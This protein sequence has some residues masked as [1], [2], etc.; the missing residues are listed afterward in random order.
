MT[1]P[2]DITKINYQLAKALQFINTYTRDTFPLF[3]STK[4]LA[5]N[6]FHDVQG[7]QNYFP[8]TCGTSEALTILGVAFFKA[9]EATNDIQWKNLGINCAE[10]YRNYFHLDDLFTTIPNGLDTPLVR[11]HWL[12]VVRL[13]K[14]GNNQKTE[15]LSN[16]SLVN[17][18][19]NFGYF[20]D[21]TFINGVAQLNTDLSRVFK[22][23]SGELEYKNVYAPLKNGMNYPIEYWVSEGQKAYPNGD[24]INTTEPNGRVKLTQNFNGTLNII[25]A[26]FDGATINPPSSTPLLGEHFLEPYPI[27]YKCKQ[28]GL[29]YTGAA[30]DA[31]WWS[32]EMY[33]IA[34]KHTNLAKYNNAKEIIK[35]NTLKYAGLESQSYFYQKSKS[36]EPLSYPGSYLLQYAVDANGV[37]QTKPGFL[38]SRETTI[39]NKLE[40]LK[41][42][43]NAN[44]NANIFSGVELQNY[45][46]QVFF[47]PLVKINLETASSIEN[48]L[49]IKI[50]LATNSNDFSQDY[51]AYKIVLG[52]SQ[53]RGYSFG[54]EQF[55]KFEN[56]NSWHPRI[57]E[58]P[59]FVFNSSSWLW[60][61]E[62][63][64]GVLRLF[65]ETNNPDS[66]AGFGLIN[67]KFSNKLP[68]IK[69]KLIG[70]GRF[71]FRDS[72][73][74]F[75]YINIAD[76]GGSW[77]TFN[78]SWQES[79]GVGD[80]Q[81]LELVFENTQNSPSILSLLYVGE[82]GKTIPVPVK[83]YKASIVDKNRLAHTWWVGDFQPLNNSLDKLP[84]TPGS[85]PFTINTLN[86]ELQGFRG[87]QFYMAYQSPYNLSKWGYLQYGKNVVQML[88][89]SQDSY[90]KQSIDKISGLL[91]Q[92]FLP[93]DNENIAYLDKAKT[94]ESVLS[95]PIPFLFDD[96]IE[97]PTDIY[98]FN[99]FSWKGLDPN[100]EWAP[101]CF[102]A[103]ED[104]SRYYLDN[105]GDRVARKV[106]ENYI[107]FA[108]AWCITNP[109]S[110]IT[111]IVPE[112]PP[113]AN[114]FEPHAAAIEGIT[115]L[116]CNL[117]GIQQTLSWELIQFKFNYID[118]QF[119]DLGNMQGSWCKNQPSFSWNNQSY[120][121]DFTFWKGKIIEFYSLCTLSK[122]YI[123]KG[124][125]ST[126]PSF[127]KIN[128]VNG[129]YVCDSPAHFVDEIIEDSFPI[130]AQKY[131]DAN[132][133]RV[134][135]NRNPI[136]K[137]IQLRYEN[138]DSTTTKQLID[139]Y[140]LVNQTPKGL[141]SFDLTSLSTN[142]F[143]GLWIFS[144]PIKVEPVV[145]NK[146]RGI[147]NVSLKIRRL[148]KF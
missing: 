143:V 8:S 107:K 13:E 77:L 75:Y 65:V 7:R 41:L 93:L 127:P 56:D 66:S 112:N 35:W 96:F 70:Q 16:P 30:F 123:T 11:N 47:D 136:N 34:Y 61:E 29:T 20:L 97:I 91:H 103:L 119:V 67:A 118:N 128:F 102:R 92:V 139:F 69:Y 37:A 52:D 101:Y 76:T 115:A 106:L 146:L 83:S 82:D 68:K 54:F 74:N 117:A 111:N 48:I 105:Q 145:A 49:E 1:L 108:H 2:F 26:R 36:L 57:A 98:E 120:Q 124:E 81:I 130:K 5:P 15:G 125:V 14:S 84:Y 140:S 116:N 18:P 44:N 72:A 62:N 12:S 21:A 104:L 147:F 28:G 27:W 51:Y 64:D 132:E 126:F 46:T 80:R 131:S 141:F 144:E 94:F 114:Y 134:L 63:V 95:S 137:T 50:S 53:P 135:L 148:R 109:N 79:L 85:I 33:E 4:F 55:L 88:S 59:V 6:A 24:K 121:E 87:K 73:N 31:Y 99:K 10:S 113:Q 129:A 19:F 39:T 133:Q 43:I 110:Q 38:A 9:F 45:V 42:E 86:G 78:S 17:D 122:D 138:L 71:R 25:F 3:F 90:Q 142:D 23:Y 22:V 100:T 40:F 32:Y 58:S 89:D 60:R